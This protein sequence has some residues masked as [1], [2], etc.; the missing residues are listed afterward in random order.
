VQDPD[1]RPYDWAAEWD[2]TVDLEVRARCDSLEHA[3]LVQSH[4]EDTIGRFNAEFLEAVIEP[5]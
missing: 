2:G 1:E 3:Q 4:L 5:T